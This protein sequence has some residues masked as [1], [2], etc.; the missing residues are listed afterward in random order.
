[1]LHAD[2][3]TKEDRVKQHSALQAA[4]VSARGGKGTRKVPEDDC[5]DDLDDDSGLDDLAHHRDGR[6][7]DS[8]SGSVDAGHD[9]RAGPRHRK[10]EQPDLSKQL[11]RVA[12]PPGTSES[13]TFYA[14]PSC[15]P[16]SGRGARATGYDAHL[17]LEMDF[18][19]YEFARL[20]P[21]RPGR[22]GC[23]PRCSRL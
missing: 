5:E 14:I 16:C 17:G 1:M 3:P 19:Y 8:E 6:P 4:L 10:R 23:A 20:G 2:A 13:H 18:E 9:V 12:C 7:V 21:Q 11:P 15:G 22:A